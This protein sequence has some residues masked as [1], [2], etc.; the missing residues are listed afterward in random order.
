[1]DC[2]ETYGS[3]PEQDENPEHITS[4]FDY[5]LHCRKTDSD[6]ARYLP[7]P[8]IDCMVTRKGEDVLASSTASTT[9]IYEEHRYAA[10]IHILML[11]ASQ[12]TIVCHG[13]DS[14]DT[15]ITDITNASMKTFGIRLTS[16]QISRIRPISDIYMP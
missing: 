7:L 2:Y 11:L 4:H 13:S 15:V 10:C 5:Y 6:V 9:S 8:L 1:V 12:N 16:D 3:V 14:H